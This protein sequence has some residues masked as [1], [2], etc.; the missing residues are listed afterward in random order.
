MGGGAYYTSWRRIEASA[1]AQPGSPGSRDAVAGSGVIG[2]GA[3]DMT[4]E[5][6][7]E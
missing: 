7:D 3:Q 4:K 6:L 5:E 2:S 1:A